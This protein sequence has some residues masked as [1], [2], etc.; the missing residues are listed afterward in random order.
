[1][2]ERYTESACLHLQKEV[3]GLVAY[4]LRNNYLMA[5]IFHHVHITGISSYVIYIAKIEAIIR[6]IQR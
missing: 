3:L 4:R 2:L 5:D 1:M 6:S